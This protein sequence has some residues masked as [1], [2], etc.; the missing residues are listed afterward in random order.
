MINCSTID[1]KLIANSQGLSYIYANLASIQ[2]YASHNLSLVYTDK[3]CL[4]DNTTKQN[5]YISLFEGKEFFRLINLSKNKEPLLKAI[6][7]KGQIINLSVADA[8]AGLARDSLLIQ[9]A[10][11][12]VDMYERNVFVYALLEDALLHAKADERLLKLKHGLPRLMDMGSLDSTKMIYDVVY[13]DPMFPPRQK[14]A[15]VKKNMQ[16]FHQIVGFD[17]DIEDN[18]SLYLKQARFKLVLKRPKD[19]PLLESKHNV[20]YSIDGGACRFDCYI[21]DNNLFG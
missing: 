14:S 4:I 5:F 1:P 2:T 15:K 16:F 13:Y 12:N 11:A 18:I 6:A 9:S 7:H 21:K 8:T 17:E 19:A 10:G 20:A 3:L